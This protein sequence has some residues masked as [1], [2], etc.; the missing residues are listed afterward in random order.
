MLFL[1]HCPG[2]MKTRGETDLIIPDISS[3]I[4][5]KSKSIEESV[6]KSKELILLND[7]ITPASP[8]Y[9]SELAAG[10]Y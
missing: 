2:E 10:V 1:Q 5:A 8:A 6:S 7:P 3:Y 9:L 4:L